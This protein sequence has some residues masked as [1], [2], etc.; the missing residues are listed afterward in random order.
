MDDQDLAAR[1]HAEAFVSRGPS[2]D[3]LYVTG[4]GLDANEWSAAL[5]DEPYVASDAE[6]AK[7]PAWARASL[8][9][10]RVTREARWG[11]HGKR[12]G[13]AYAALQREVSHQNRTAALRQAED[14]RWFTIC[15]CK[16]HGLR[17][18]DPEVARREFD[19]H[20]CSVDGDAAVERAVEN[21]DRLVYG[22][23]RE[24]S[25]MAP[26]EV[27]ETAPVVTVVE[28]GTEQ[29]MALLELK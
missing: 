28:D 10:Q 23:K 7:M 22:P 8:L 29:R 15:A 1:P 4:S 13:A 2:D 9:K 6:L 14:G 12:C 18:D 19:A 21:V 3:K 27:G 24:A 26:A 17:V 5:G 20:A 25:T 11:L 16:W